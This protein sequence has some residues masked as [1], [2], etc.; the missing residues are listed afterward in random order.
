MEK[1]GV[2]RWNR[3]KFWTFARNDCG[4]SSQGFEK[5][6]STC[7][8]NARAYFEEFWRPFKKNFEKLSG[9]F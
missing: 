6:L 8:R 5:I 3:I 1:C 2:D 7:E 9:K 4:K